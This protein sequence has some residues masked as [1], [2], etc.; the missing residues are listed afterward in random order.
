MLGRTVRTAR[1]TTMHGLIGE[2]VTAGHDVPTDASEDIVPTPTPH[3]GEIQ[4][5]PRAH[6]R[7]LCNVF[8]PGRDEEALIRSLDAAL[9]KTAPPSDVQMLWGEHKDK[10]RCWKRHALG[11]WMLRCDAYQ[12]SVMEMV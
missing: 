1:T 2:W 11:H 6:P 7:L 5:P 10:F 12:L 4:I 3:S 9:S 8:P